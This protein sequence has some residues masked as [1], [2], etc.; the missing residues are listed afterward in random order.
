MTDAFPGP[1]RSI[2]DR[3]EVFVAYLDYFRSTV[4]EKVESLPEGE[5]RASR[6]PS[7]WAPVEL[8]KHLTYVERRWLEWGF[9]GLD[10]GEPW[11]DSRDGRWYVGPEE[12]LDD[13]L[14]ALRAQ[15]VRTTEIVRASDLDAAGEPG[16]RWDGDDPATM[17]R[18]LFH[19]V[20]E[21]AR[22]AGHL[23]I[24][25]ELAGGRQGE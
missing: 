12:S 5:R 17:E 13:L 16:D 9:R 4:V 20:Q 23:D 24:V 10:V 2:A 1:T 3:R 19:L 11:G 21:Y 14:A 6:L 22:H 7:G 18:I 25:A 8:V 15:G